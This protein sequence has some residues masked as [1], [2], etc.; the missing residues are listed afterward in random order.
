MKKDKMICIRLTNMQKENILRKAD[1]ANMNITDYMIKSA[2][3]RKIEIIQINELENFILEL[4]RIGN[5]L[6]QL[7]RLANSGCV[8]IVDLSD[9]KNEVVNIWQSLNLLTQKLH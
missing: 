9:V 2:L 1:Y 3:K 7:T 5:N 8:K 4:K 6:N